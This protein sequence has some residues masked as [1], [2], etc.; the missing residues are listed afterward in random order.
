MFGINMGLFQTH[1]T[2]GR[3]R[4]VPWAGPRVEVGSTMERQ[5]SFTPF[6]GGEPMAEDPW[7][8]GVCLWLTGGP[9]G[10]PNAGA[11]Q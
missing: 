5:E 4:K 6:S 2:Q 7:P 3:K 1:E 9:L 8:S 11:A 10:S